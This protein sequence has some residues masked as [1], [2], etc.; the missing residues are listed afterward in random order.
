VSGA[1]I[2][3][4]LYKDWKK[5]RIFFRHVTAGLFSNHLLTKLTY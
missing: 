5:G 4:V 1:L 3:F 2:F